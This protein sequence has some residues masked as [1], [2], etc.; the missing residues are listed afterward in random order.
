MLYKP[1][2]CRLGREICTPLKPK[3]RLTC[4]VQHHPTKTEAQIAAEARI[5]P[6]DLKYYC[7]DTRTEKISAEAIVRVASVTGRWDLIDDLVIPYG[8]RLERIEPGAAADLQ[9]ELNDVMVATGRVVETYQRAI[10]NHHI[11]DQERVEIM[12]RLRTVIREVEQALS[13]AQ[14]P[15]H[16]PQVVNMA[17]GRR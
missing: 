4:A 12:E 10:R 6:R 13:A 5:R 8:Y 1:S 2:I 16:A 17:G 14:P 7:Q 9:G 11:D 15:A 3:D